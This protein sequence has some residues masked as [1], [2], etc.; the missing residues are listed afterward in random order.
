[1]I[2]TLQSSI[3]F[4]LEK[5]QFLSTISTC[6]TSILRELELTI[7]LPF[8]QMLKSPWREVEFVSSESQFIPELLRGILSVVE[9]VREGLELKKYARSLCDK[10]VGFVSFHFAVI[11]H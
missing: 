8:A 11:R 3:S 2:P 7:E 9:A 10:V 5:D 4:T 1:M 6:M